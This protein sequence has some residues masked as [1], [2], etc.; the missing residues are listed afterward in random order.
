[1][2]NVQKLHEQVLYSQVR[3]K[4]GQGGGSGTIIYSNKFDS[5]YST[6]VLTCHHVIDSAITVKKEWDSRLGRDRKK[7]YRQLVTVDFFDYQNSPHGS[8]PVTYSTPAEIVAYD[9]PHDMA[10]LKLRTV[11]PAKYTANLYPKGEHKDINIGTKTIAVGSALLH[12]PIIT[13]GI[14]THQGDEIDYKIYWMSSA[15]IIF[16]NSGGAMFA[17]RDGNYYFI[18]VPSRVDVVGWGSAVTHLGYFS[19]IPRVYDFF[20]EQLFHFLVPGSKHTESDCLK[21]QESREER[22]ERRLYLEGVENE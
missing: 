7:E 12:D 2:E 16:G 6:Y 21:E 14:I 3:V 9:T 13:E 5:H 8:V 11:E 1:M 20:K 18:G 4:A 10:I 19:P 17:E 22:E 15:Q